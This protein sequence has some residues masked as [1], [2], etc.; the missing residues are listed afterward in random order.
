MGP[1]LLQIGS[2]YC[3]WGFWGP[4][5]N[6]HRMADMGFCRQE[7]GARTPL[8]LRRLVSTSHA[9]PRCGVGW[10]RRLSPFRFPWEQGRK[11]CRDRR[12]GSY[13]LLL[14]QYRTLGH[15]GDMALSPGHGTAL[16]RGLLQQRCGRRKRIRALL[17]ITLTFQVML[18]YSM[19]EGF[20]QSRGSITRSWRPTWHF[21]QLGTFPQLLTWSSRSC[22]KQGRPQWSRPAGRVLRGSF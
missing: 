9:K 5:V 7:L 19:P 1:L 12:P 20:C 6:G 22:G 14:C 2:C 8:R 13:D 16:C 18:F 11:P 15:G 21:A 17:T 10:W 3:Y 4:G